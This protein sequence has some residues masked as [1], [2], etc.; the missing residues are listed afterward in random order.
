MSAKKKAAKKAATPEK[1][2]APKKVVKKASKRAAKKVPK[3][4]VRKVSKKVAVTRKATPAPTSEEIG[5]AAYLLFLRRR[6]SGAPGT[7][8]GDWLEAERLLSM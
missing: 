7:A 1:V 4:A 2:T 8:E 6:E 5:K 3:K